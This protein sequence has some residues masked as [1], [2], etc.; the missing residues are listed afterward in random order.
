MG[1]IDLLEHVLLVGGASCRRVSSV[2]DLLGFLWV[3]AKCTCNFCIWNWGYNFL[4]FIT[5][6]NYKESNNIFCFNGEFLFYLN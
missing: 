2:Q 5:L 4:I 3:S 6:L 1:Y